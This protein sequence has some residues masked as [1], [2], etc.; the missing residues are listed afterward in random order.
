MSRRVSR[1]IVALAVL[2]LGGSA[3]AVLS[4]VMSG[5]ATAACAP[6][7]TVT[8]HAKAAKKPK[9]HA[10]R[11]VVSKLHRKKY[12]AKVA[13]TARQGT[14]TVVAA[15]SVC[16]DGAA[17]AA[18]STTQSASGKGTMT[19]TVSA[20]G[21]SKKAAKKAVKAKTKKAV[22]KL[23]KKGATKKGRR[24]AK[25]R[26]IAVA[27]PVA[28]SKAHDALYLSDVVYLTLDSSKTYHI[29]SSAPAGSPT[30]SAAANGDLVYS[31]PAGYDPSTGK[32]APCI[33]RA[34]VWPTSFIFDGGDLTAAAL[35]GAATSK[36][37]YFGVQAEPLPNVNGKAQSSVTFPD[38]AWGA[39]WQHSS[40]GPAQYTSGVSSPTPYAG[41]VECVVPAN[42]N[43]KIAPAYTA[44]LRG[45]HVGRTANGSGP[46][47]KVTGGVP[48]RLR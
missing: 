6:S 10:A 39:G 36:T 45:A 48:V 35:Q 47:A 25:K 37:G 26:A 31:V 8:P 24:K 17:G 14:A 2:P 13:I 18:A 43:T 32:S 38:Q 11:P 42:N 21:H 5:S 4:P 16:P 19:K 1:G 33:R 27:R 22:A 29:T 23:K 3:L 28:V 9:V 44:V 7:L 12:V 15:Q 30:L 40:S 34:P 41:V 20:K 46:F